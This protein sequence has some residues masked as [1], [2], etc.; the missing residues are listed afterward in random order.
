[1][2]QITANVFSGRPDPSWVITD[3]TEAQTIL[4]HLLKDPQL[5][6]DAAPARAGLGVSR[7]SIVDVAEGPAST[8]TGGAVVRERTSNLFSHTQEQ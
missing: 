5:L 3:E 4:Q 7:T 6:A 2:L 8:A 1:M